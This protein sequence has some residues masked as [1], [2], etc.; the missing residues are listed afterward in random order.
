MRFGIVYSI[1]G[2]GG[3]SAGRVF[4]EA[5]EEILLAESLG[6]ECAF[7]S[8]HHFVENDFF[9]SP[10]IALSYIAA[11]TARIRLGPGVLLLP[12]YDPIH[13]AEDAA[14]LDIISGG[15]LVLGIGQG[16]RPEEFRAFG[17][18][19]RDRP[20]LLREGVEVIRGLWTQ[21][22]FTYAGKRF[23]TDRLPL[24]PKPVQKPSP[25]IWVAA[26]K[27][28]AVAL[29]GEIGD[30]WFAD[31][32]T[33]LSIIRDNRRHWEAALTARGKDVRDQSFAYYR[34][35]FV[36]EDD[37]SAWEI[38]REPM[39]AG[40][41]N[42]LRWGHLVDD[43]GRP[44]APERVD[45][46]EQL[47]RKRFTLGGPGRCREDLQMIR[48]TLDPTHLVMKMKFPGLS[49]ELVMG[50]VRRFGEQVMPHAGH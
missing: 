16:Y 1:E 2:G 42:Y 34:E 46:L 26:K 3:D 4:Q 36:A 48:D 47:V 10:L 43:E 32:I 45:V 30:G 5:V 39:M 9:P 19:V 33:P 41:R 15:R 31:P 24:K 12:L 44:I 50:S 35:F 49:H 40:Y 7:V 37:R 38:G 22:S 17:A 14:V 21:D 8:E 23:Q 20:G 27:R 18:D 25:P 11:R 13:V 28:S 29:A 6:L